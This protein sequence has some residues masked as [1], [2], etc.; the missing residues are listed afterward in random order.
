MAGNPLQY[1]CLENSRGIWQVIIH[2]VTRVRH[3]WVTE[4]VHVRAHTHT[5]NV[6]GIF[7][8]LHLW[9]TVGYGLLTLYMSPCVPISGKQGAARRYILKR[10]KWARLRSRALNDL[11]CVCIQSIIHPVPGVAVVYPLGT[12]YC[13]GIL[14]SKFVG[15]TSSTLSLFGLF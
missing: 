6:Y 3:N 9:P 2:G 8:S 4:C 14:S 10:Q 12:Y 15:L 11:T 1:S 13:I 5:K 7:Y